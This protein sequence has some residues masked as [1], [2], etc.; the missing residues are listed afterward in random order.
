MLSLCL[1]ALEP[2]QVPQNIAAH[3][4]V[5][6]SVNGHD[7]AGSESPRARRIPF[8]EIESLLWRAAAIDLAQAWASAAP[9]SFVENLYGPTEATIAC[10]AYPFDI[11]RANA[12]GAL[13]TVPIGHPFG[14]TTT[15][16]VEVG[17]SIEVDHDDDGEL[18]LA[19]PQVVSGYW[20]DS[21]ATRGSFVEI[22]GRRYYRTGDRVRRRG[23]DGTLVFIGRIDDQ[24]K[25]RGHRVELGEIE[26][27]LRSITGSAVAAVGW[28][29][30]PAG[31]SGI[32]AFVTVPPLEV[33]QLRRSLAQHL[34][35]YMVPERVLFVD[36]LP[37]N[38]SGKCDRNALIGLLERE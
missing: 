14:D 25:V 37:L 20:N 27:V 16:V 18:L 2:V 8:P 22:Q 24:I 7:D 31:A 38:A 4:L 12:E 13:G 17:G 30:T 21:L 26:A 3:D 5:R 15:T 33:P 29:C 34:P 10:T 28:P 6:G 32:A 19:G 23:S 11:E 1:R 36:Q 9:N 35:K